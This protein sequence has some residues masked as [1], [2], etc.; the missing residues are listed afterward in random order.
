MSFAA[1]PE[2]PWAPLHRVLAEKAWDD[3]CPFWDEDGQG[4][5]IGTH[6]ADGYKIHLFKMTADGKSLI[7]DSEVIY[8]SHGSEAHKLY[9]INA[10]IIIFLVR[11]VTTRVLMMA[12]AKKIWGLQPHG[13]GTSSPKKIN[14]LYLIHSFRSVRRQPIG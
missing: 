2:E 10:I 4:Y 11:C 12:S 5:L 13:S 7:K 6:F 3:C 1:K 9:K 8:Q 14:G